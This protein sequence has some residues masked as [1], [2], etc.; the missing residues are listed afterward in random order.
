M[1]E[2]PITS[3]RSDLMGGV[4]FEDDT[5]HRWLRSGAP[6]AVEFPGGLVGLLDRRPTMLRHE[7]R[8]DRCPEEEYYWGEAIVTIDLVTGAREVAFCDPAGPDGG[9]YPISLGGDLLVAVATE[10]WEVRSAHTLVFLDLEGQPIDVATNPF[11]E[12]CAPC[13]LTAR[14]SPDGS[15]LAY[16]HR[17]DAYW[18]QEVAEALT[19]DEWW[20]QSRSIPAD[21]VVIDLATGTELLRRR[22]DA[23]VSLTD[24]D[25]SRIAEW[26]HE[27][28]ISTI[29]DIATGAETKAAG[30]IVLIPDVVVDT[31]GGPFLYVS[32]PQPDHPPTVWN[33][34]VA[35]QVVTF[36]GIT[37]PGATVTA[38]GRYPATVDE[39]GNWSVVLVLEP[40]PNTA[41][42]TARDRDG[43]TTDTSYPV[44]YAIDFRDLIVGI[45]AG[46]VTVPSMWSPITDC[47]IEFR[48]DGSYSASSSGPTPAFYYGTNE[49]HPD[50][51][52][53]VFGSHPSQEPGSGWITIV[54]DDGTTRQGRLD[55][56]RL[57]EDGNRLEFEFWN[58]W[59]GVDNPV[60]YDLAQL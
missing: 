20:E 54:W 38:S 34:T 12:S 50:K 29:I 15:L 23:E 26:D 24:F 9:T 58:T 47:R 40:G 49:D 18:P 21:V 4:F 10:E 1:V 7:A 33:P 17:P 32:A 3:A 48:A 16:R 11:S 19:E 13:E 39:A 60:V 6:G 57:S 8:Y 35:D 42:F 43:G 36:R 46:E 56:I 44:S 27:R 28:E 52:Y 55:N 30:R 53:E 37:T 41:T 25:G 22:V 14:L 5:G 2:G 51:A 45:W 31:T 59:S